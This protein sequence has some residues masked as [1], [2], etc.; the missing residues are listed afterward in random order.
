ME[1]AAGAVGARRGRRRLAPALAFLVGVG[2]LVCVFF[3]PGWQGGPTLTPRLD[4]ARF[5]V[6]LRSG[7]SWLGPF[8]AAAAM[9]PALRALVWREVL[10]APPPRLEDCYHA[11]ALGTLLHNVVPGK[12][13]PLGA[14]Y[15]LSRW[16]RRPL[17]AALSSQLVAKLLELGV[18]VALGVVAVAVRPSGALR[19]VVG[20]GTAALALLAS[21]AVSLALGAPRLA[22]RLARR[23]PRAGDVVASLGAGLVGAG[24]PSRLG[25]AAGLAALPAVAAA[26][27]YGLPLHAAGVPGSAAGGALLLVVI[28]FGQF[29]PGLPVGAGVHWTLASWAARELGASPE[30]AAA[31]AVLTHAGMVAAGLLAGAASALA[32]R[33]ALR[34]LL[35]WRRSLA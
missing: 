14:A 28:A 20:G 13:G 34:E 24:S 21:V 8:V 30:D 4:L 26:L 9:L 18:V 15:V 7:G 35:R 19:E 25:A 6:R 16:D 10:P 23:L 29:T 33:G 12:L 1:G 17:A 2:L 31:L 5:L 32:R 27:A 11:T 3:V 22:A